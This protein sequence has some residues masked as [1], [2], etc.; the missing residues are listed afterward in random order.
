MAHEQSAVTPPAPAPAPPPKVWIVTQ[1]GVYTFLVTA[2]KEPLNEE[3]APPTAF[4][5]ITV[6]A[7]NLFQVSVISEAPSLTAFPTSMP[8]QLICLTIGNLLPH[9]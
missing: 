8:L 4:A 3:R 5:S 9:P 2:F 6:V 1:E 7:R